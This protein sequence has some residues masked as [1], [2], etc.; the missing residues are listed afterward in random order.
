MLVFISI[1][2]VLFLA[3]E[4]KPPPEITDPGQLLFLGYAKQDV[5]CSK[6]HGA[7][8][9]G[10]MDAPDIRNAFQKYGKGEIMN[11]IEYGKGEGPDAMPPFEGKISEEELLELVIFLETLQRSS[12][13]SQVEN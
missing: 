7:D 1:I 9:Q 12:S 13:D 5:N 3:C 6:C 11:I 2:L 10:G 8:G 4:S